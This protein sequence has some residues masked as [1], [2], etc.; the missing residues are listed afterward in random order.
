M[1]SYK[2]LYET[3]N[4]DDFPRASIY[5]NNLRASMTNKELEY[6]MTQYANPIIA[7]GELTNE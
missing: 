5:F 2:Y 3:V 6:I 1:Y 4:D 7:K